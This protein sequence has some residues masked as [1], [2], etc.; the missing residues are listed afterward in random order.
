MRQHVTG[1]IVSLCLLAAARG[2]QAQERG[3]CLPRSGTDEIAREDENLDGV[4]T[5]AEADDM[6]ARM[7]EHF[8]SNRDGQVTRE[9]VEQRA[10][11]WRQRRFEERFAALDRDHDGALSSREVA[12]PPRR[13]ARADRDGDR[14]LTRSEL[15]AASVGGQ[16]GS[17]DT[18][19]LRAMFWRRDLDRDRRVT[20]AE[21]LTFAERRFRR[22]DRDG[23]G[24]L[25][26][27]EQRQSESAR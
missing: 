15:W 2:A 17:G 20:R 19:A 1:V 3:D 11:S 12:L 25:T 10:A 16:R 21:A 6:A 23:N 24:V 14:R 18:A 27:D 26:R 4:V 5:L 7:F 8:D 9:E 22:R 13:F